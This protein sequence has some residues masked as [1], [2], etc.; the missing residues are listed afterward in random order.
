MTFT[1]NYTVSIMNPTLHLRFGIDIEGKGL[2]SPNHAV[3]RIPLKN[4]QIFLAFCNDF[5]S[6][7]Q[8]FAYI[9]LRSKTIL[10]LR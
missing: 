1:D 9:L 8:M 5:E 10:V 3:L 7:Y 6:H 4:R 2:L